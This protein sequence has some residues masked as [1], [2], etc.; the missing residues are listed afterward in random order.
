MNLHARISIAVLMLVL[1]SVGVL[2]PDNTKKSREQ[3]ASTYGK[4]SDGYGA[5]FDFL[6]ELGFSAGRNLVSPKQL[7]A[8]PAAGKT[9]WWIEP[10]NLCERSETTQKNVDESNE[11]AQAWPG[12]E[13]IE[14]GGTA[15][16]FLTSVDTHAYPDAAG[17]AWIYN[18]ERIGGF[19]LPRR[20][21]PEW[22]RHEALRDPKLFRVGDE[23]V[24][25]AAWSLWSEQALLR[26]IFDR[27][28]DAA[29][30]K[31]GG[32]A[33]DSLFETMAQYLESDF[34]S[35]PRTLETQGL[36]AFHDDL[37]WQVRG[38]L[39]GRPFILEHEVGV[40][41]LV[42]IADVAFLRNGWFDSADSAPL[43][44]DLVRTYGTP[45]FDEYEHGFRAER[46]A[47]HYL[48]RSRALPLFVGLALFGALYAWRGNAYSRRSVREIDVGVPTLE[49]FVDSVATLY[50]RT[51]DFERVF[52]C[53]RELTLDRIRRHCG[54]TPSAPL[55]EL[56]ERLEH[57]PH[58]SR[59]M[60]GWLVAPPPVK[61]AGELRAAV[62]MLDLLF[63][64]VRR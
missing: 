7:A 30:Q 28:L 21:P 34:S 43:A 47:L 61:T 22:R 45:V 46:N 63:D 58:V 52:A 26:G 12:T 11:S 31:K 39:D 37:D 14:Q 36:L 23:S 42:V 16:V 57:D 49:T 13:W 64:A 10:Q 55:R 2:L 60:L 41:R 51:H 29:E 19:A 33:R 17:R 56:Q 48:L 35:S 38:T 6:Q 18:C 62:Q 44:M 40:G 24:K 15:L 59:K 50:S 27:K 54:L 4:A 32:G 1:I 5:L 8:Q 9:I 3:T 25:L 53:Y 20:V